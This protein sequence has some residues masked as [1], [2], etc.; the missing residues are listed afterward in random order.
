[1]HTHTRYYPRCDLHLLNLLRDMLGRGVVHDLLR[2]K[3]I[4]LLSINSIQPTFATGPTQ[5]IFEA[6]IELVE[7]A[8]ALQGTS[9]RRC[10]R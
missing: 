1:M 6:G 5:P 8:A 3:S 4:D 7:L 10:I 9:S 2:K